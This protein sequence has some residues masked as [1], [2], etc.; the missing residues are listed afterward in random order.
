VSAISGG[1]NPKTRPA[2]AG[3]A[4][5]STQF[6]EIGFGGGVDVKRLAKVRLECA[7]APIGFAFS[8]PFRSV[9]VSANCSSDYHP[10]VTVRNYLTA[11]FVI[12]RE[13]A[14]IRETQEMK[15]SIFDCGARSNRVGRRRGYDHQT[16]PHRIGS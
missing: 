1:V 6:A 14:F 7:S 3:R 10:E 8:D 9:L 5:V 12:R 2:P 15:P 4:W 13:R 11:S 16:V